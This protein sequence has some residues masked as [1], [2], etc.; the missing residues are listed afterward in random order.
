VIG[1][2]E[3]TVGLLHAASGLAFYFSF[4][5]LWQ[6]SASLASSSSLLEQ[7][8]QPLYGRCF[9]WLQPALKMF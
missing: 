7:H 5:W 8:F 6:V 4:R 3:F 9:L 1:R 2:S